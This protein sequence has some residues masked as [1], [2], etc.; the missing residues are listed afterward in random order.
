MRKISLTLL[1]VISISSALLSQSGY[2]PLHRD[3]E[4]MRLSSSTPAKNFHPSTHPWRLA[5]LPAD[6]SHL[7]L[8][9]PPAKIR[10]QPLLQL[11][12]GAGTGYFLHATPGA[13]LS[14]NPGPRL[15]LSLRYRA[16]LF[17][18][19]PG[20]S[21]T[22]DSG[23]I[24]HYGASLH[25]YGKGM[26]LM[27][28]LTGY[29]SWSPL[30]SINLQLG[31]DRNFW[32][33]GYRSLFLSDNAAAYPFL[34]TT[35]AAW[36]IRYVS[37]LTF[38][39]DVDLPGNIKRLHPKYTALHYLSW[40]VNEK[41]N[42]ALFESVIWRGNDSSMFRGFDIQYINPAVFYRPIEFSIG[43]P[44]NVLLGLAGSLGI[45]RNSRFYGQFLLDEFVLKRML[46]EHDWWANKW[47]IQLGLRTKD[48]FGLEGLHLLMEV[49][50]VRPYTWSHSSTLRSFGYLYQ[51]MAHPLGAN[52][53]EGILNMKYLKEKHLFSASIIFQQAGTDS[54]SGSYGGDIY[55]TYDLR[56]SD[57]GNHTLQG[58]KRERMLIDLHYSRMLIPAW[59]LVLE[60]GGLAR[61]PTGN[62]RESS[63]GYLYISLKTLLNND[64]HFRY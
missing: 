8:S 59:D 45:T 25:D 6:S 9:Q 49:N 17:R 5:D 14:W 29:L 27:Q 37:L 24:P 60:L 13:A 54:S 61:L 15:N 41:I 58:V 35:L 51:P 20:E 56:F 62:N 23:Y 26:Q 40:D 42:L 30:P 39:Q 28:D 53:R 43:S 32:G 63:A 16:G 57:L 18:L 1:F 44:D 12:T 33:E 50:S 46:K 47:G 10:L 11:T 4:L 34:K 31:I 3:L 64:E 7:S 22:A 19:P 2:L 55:K 36:H 48:A 21:F 52:F 38:L